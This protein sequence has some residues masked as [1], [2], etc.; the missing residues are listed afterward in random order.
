MGSVL[1]PCCAELFGLA[2]PGHVFFLH[3]GIG[4]LGAL[5]ATVVF[6]G[7]AGRI[8][9]LPRAVGIVFVGAVVG[10]GAVLPRL[11]NRLSRA[12]VP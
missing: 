2:A 6:A 7:L 8:V 3:G 12:G 10:H 1:P 11:T 9:A 5:D 4:T